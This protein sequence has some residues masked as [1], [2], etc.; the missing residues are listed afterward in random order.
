MTPRGPKQT[1]EIVG[2][3][4]PSTT[5]ETASSRPRSSTASGNEERRSAREPS[6]VTRRTR[7]SSGLIPSS[8]RISGAWVDRMI[9]RSEERRACASTEGRILTIALLR[10]SSGSS[11]SR[12]P[13]FAGVLMMAHSRPM[14]R[15]VPSEKS[16]SFC[17]EGV[18][19][20]FL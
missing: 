15:R 7:T 9:W 12:I 20:Q 16:T 17:L 6:S 1:C 4:R 14:S 13:G 8:S 3:M 11:S 10:E 2:A 18:D 19:R 5:S